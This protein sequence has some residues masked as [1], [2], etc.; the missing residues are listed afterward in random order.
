MSELEVS[1][2]N[3]FAYD[4]IA[5]AEGG[6][7]FTCFNALSGD[8]SMWLNT[9]GPALREKGHGLL[10]WNLRGQ[11]DTTY[12]VSEMGE[13]EIVDDAM[14]LFEA[15]N[16]T[17]PVH[18]GLSIGGLFAIRAHERGGAGRSH[19][20]VLIN[21]LR[22]QGPRL[23]WVNHAVARTAE[24]GGLD[25]LRDLFSPLLMNVDWQAENRA[26]FLTRDSYAPLPSGD[27]ALMLLKGGIGANWDVAYEDI[28]VPVLSVTGLQDRVFLDRAHV[29]ELSARIPTLTRVDLENAGHM[30]PVERPQELAAAVLG[31]A[32]ALSTS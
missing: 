13:R 25:L 21:T 16:P 20:I 18:I 31:F 2:G 9:I 17:R 23:D 15:V 1:P 28:D 32:D 14:A 5:P 8:R 12:T 24:V 29:D 7:T 19:G 27:G 10:V 22:K 6:F 26:N 11:A 4:H 30:I 3:A